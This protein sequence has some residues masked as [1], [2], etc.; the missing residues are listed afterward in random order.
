[1]M[2]TWYFSTL[3]L[4]IRSLDTFYEE[5]NSIQTVCI[6]WGCRYID[7]MPQSLQITEPLCVTPWLPGGWVQGPIAPGN[8]HMTSRDVGADAITNW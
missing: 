1:M 5:I 3:I 8:S 2:S 6:V 7:F 4:C